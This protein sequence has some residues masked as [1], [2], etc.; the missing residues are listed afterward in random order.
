MIENPTEEQKRRLKGIIYLI[1]NNI[2]GQ[3][4]VGKATNSFTI[5]YP[6]NKWWQKQNNDCKSDVD[7]YEKENFS[8][9]ILPPSHIPTKVSG[10]ILYCII[11]DGY[12]LVKS[13]LD[14]QL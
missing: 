12:K 1:I 13:K 9:S 7:K 8:I 3:K 14:T 4:Y 6:G 11:S 10:E 2:T 5:R